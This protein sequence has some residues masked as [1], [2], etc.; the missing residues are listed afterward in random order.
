MSPMIR[1]MTVVVAVAATLALLLPAGGASVMC[2]DDTDMIDPWVVF[3]F[4]EC[5]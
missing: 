4:A 3:Q 1:Q 5:G 2:D